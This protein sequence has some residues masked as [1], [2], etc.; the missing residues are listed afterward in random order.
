MAMETFLKESSKKK[1]R[2]ILVNLPLNGLWSVNSHKLVMETG[3][4]FYSN[5]DLYEGEFYDEEPHGH[6]NS[7]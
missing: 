4:H 3:K 7:I 2:L 1:M 6:G 5:G